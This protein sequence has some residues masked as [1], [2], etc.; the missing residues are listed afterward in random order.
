S[1]ILA[2]PKL[3]M[4]GI[5]FVNVW[6]GAA[7]PMVLFIAGLQSVP[8]YLHE[9]GKLD[10]ASAFQRFRKITVPFLIPVLSIVLILNIKSGLTTF[11]YIMAMTGGGP[12]FS[13][14]SIGVLIYK[15]GFGN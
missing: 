12:G 11:E 10:G 3:V 5:V 2:N 9:A 13:T 6:Q 7:I 8:Q 15:Q 4:Y 1:N 14:E